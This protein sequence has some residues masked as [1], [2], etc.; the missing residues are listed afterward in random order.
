MT[1]LG[2]RCGLYTAD[3]EDTV[4]HLHAP[5]VLINHSLGGVIVQRYI[6]ARPVP[7]AILMAAGPPHG[8]L[9]SAVG[10]ALRNPRLFQELSI[11]G[12]RVRESAPWASWRVR[13]SRRP[14]PENEADRRIIMVNGCVSS[15]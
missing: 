10:M 14:C 6:R 13:C 3:L 15:G 7:A 2:L 11:I 1:C 5:P 8:M 4:A 12:K 9:P